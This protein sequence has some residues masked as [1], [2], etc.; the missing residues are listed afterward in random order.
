MTAFCA[1]WDTNRSPFDANSIIRAPGTLSAY[2]STMNPAGA[3][4]RVPS[5]RSTTLPKFGR[6]SLGAGTCST[7]RCAKT[8]ADTHRIPRA[9]HLICRF[10]FISHSKFGGYRPPLQFLLGR[11]RTRF[12]DGHRKD[13]N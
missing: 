8:T 7:P 6:A 4:G 13:E 10:L 5:G 2:K 12:S 3:F 1:G 11:Y 9:T